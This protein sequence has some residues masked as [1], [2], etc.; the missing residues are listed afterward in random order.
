MH[1][2]L[3]EVQCFCLNGGGGLPPFWHAHPT[4]APCLVLGT[5]PLDWASRVPAECPYRNTWGSGYQLLFKKPSPEHGY[6]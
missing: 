4:L 5:T 3:P 6:Q 2:L 1:R